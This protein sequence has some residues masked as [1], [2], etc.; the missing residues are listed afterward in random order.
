[1]TF[2]TLAHKTATS[3]RKAPYGEDAPQGFSLDSHQ[4]HR[5]S[6]AGATGADKDHPACVVVTF[7]R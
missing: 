2:E 1:M 7:R 3:K 4:W 6:V 5:R